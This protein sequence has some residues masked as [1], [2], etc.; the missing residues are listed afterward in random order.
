LIEINDGGPSSCE[1]NCAST[2]T[3]TCENSHLHLDV[4]GAACTDVTSDYD[5]TAGCNGLGGALTFTTAQATI[6][7]AAANTCAGE[8]D[9]GF[10]N[11]DAGLSREC[12]LEPDAGSA[13]L[14]ANHRACV[15]KPASGRVCI[16]HASPATCP[17][18]FTE[19]DVADSYTDTRSCPSCACGW[20]GT[21]CM[22]PVVGAYTVPACTGTAAATL[23]A[24]CG[25]VSGGPF[26]SLGV[27]GTDVA[28]TCGVT[29]AGALD[30]G[31]TI[32][33]GEIVCCSN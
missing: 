4:G 7:V 3:P 12:V 30:G 2:G 32:T 22:N 16:A 13:N 18:G 24:A 11:P 29:D 28:P 27:T 17:S 23:P 9:A 14:C 8:T 20:S 15:T 25:A 31:V 6:S 19:T 10:P 21:G 26:A 33:N 5:M 1:C